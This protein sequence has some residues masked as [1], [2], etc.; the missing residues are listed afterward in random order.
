VI[1]LA[2]SNVRITKEQALTR[3]AL[4]E[5]KANYEAAEEQRQRAEK[6]RQFARQAVDDMYLGVGNQW[7]NNQSNLEPVQRDFLVKALHFYEEFAR[8]QG[9]DPAL[10]ERIAVAYHRVGE[11]QKRLGQT[12]KAQE[13][14]GQAVACFEQLTAESPD[15]VAYREQLALAHQKRGELFWATRRG[16]EAEADWRRAG[17]L[18]EKLV[19]EFPTQ[20]HHRHDLAVTQNTLG[21][22][23]R[24]DGRLAEAEAV[25]RQ[26]ADLLARLGAEAPPTALGY[27]TNL[28]ST[29]LCLGWVL[30]DAS[31]HLESEQAFRQAQA[32]FDKLAARMPHESQQGIARCQQSLGYVL[33]CLDRPKEAEKPY[34]TAL[35]LWQKLAEQFPNRADWHSQLALS[36]LSLGRLLVTLDRP[37]EAEES[38]RRTLSVPQGSPEVHCRLAY[39]RATCADPRFRDPVQALALA[40]KAVAALP[41]SALSWRTLGMAQCSTRDWQA[42]IAALEKSMQ[43]SNGGD[44]YDWVF[45]AMAHWH[46]GDRELARQWYDRALQRIKKSTPDEELRRFQKEAAA[47][48]GIPTQGRDDPPW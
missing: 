12:A 42:A 10:Q 40:Q 31:R 16:Q 9:P 24:A 7:L 37:E 26:S 15:V 2:I 27:Q 19:A 25:F 1:G 5:A 11:I 44:G 38:F 45:L 17:A 32:V 6:Q 28:A 47:L 46:R 35:A 41:D 36:H 14:Y 48:L 30:L 3:E 34:R 8:E 22:L 29:Y 20:R 33:V 21:L 23:L 4:M 18:R 13:A 43:L 39:L